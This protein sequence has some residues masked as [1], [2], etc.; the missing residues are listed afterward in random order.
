MTRRLA[1]GTVALG[2]QQLVSMLAM[3]FVHFI[4]ARRLGP[5]SYG[6]LAVALAVLS[7]VSVTL[8]MGVPHTIAKFVAED[9]SRT[10]YLLTWGLMTQTG[11][12]LAVGLGLALAS[13]PLAAVLGE[14]RLATP[15]FFIALAAPLT[16]IS[17]VH[18]HVLNGLQAFGRQAAGLGAMTLLKAAGILAFVLAGLGVSGAMQGVMYGAVVGVIVT[19][20]LIGGLVTGATRMDAGR[21]FLFAVQLT[22]TY[23][24]VEIWY[25][26]DLVLLQILGGDNNEV[27]FFWCGADPYRRI[28]GGVSAVVHHAVSTGIGVVRART[29]R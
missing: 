2:V 12:A 11:L 10:R 7:M 15:L 28:G 5:S 24:V 6:I 25:E 20:G 17:Y 21:L 8:F 27:G 23:V 1:R 19:A 13:Q 3:M 14:P 16:G 18:L 29:R 22:G 4:V 26:T 9:A